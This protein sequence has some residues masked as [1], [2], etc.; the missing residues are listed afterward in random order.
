MGGGYEI[1]YFKGYVDVG[2]VYEVFGVG[3][4]VMG[5]VDVCVGGGVFR[6][7]VYMYVLE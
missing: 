2:Y 6:N 4:C 3:V 5:I 1:N 7:F